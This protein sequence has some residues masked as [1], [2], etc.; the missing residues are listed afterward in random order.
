M[1]SLKVAVAAF[2]APPYS[3]GGVVSAHFNLF[4]SLKAEGLDVK[5]WTYCFSGP[6]R[7]TNASL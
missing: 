6:S 4:R 5:M 3:A 1:R 7:C 2:S